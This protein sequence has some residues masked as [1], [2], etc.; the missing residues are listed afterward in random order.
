M[1][2]IGAA[3]VFAASTAIGFRIARDYRERPRQLRSLSQGIRLLQAEVEY[4][5]T[6][7]PIALERVA[8]RVAPPVSAGFHRAAALLQEGDIPVAEA[9]AAGM[10]ELRSGSALH[11]VDLD[12]MREL[13]QTLGTSDRAHQR[14]QFEVAIRRLSG[15]EEDALELQRTH[16]RLW[17]YVGALIGLTIV[18]LLY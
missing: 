17:R 18:I 14:Q 2:A 4:G 12:V 15:L 6:P 5:L 13:G 9:V 16:E 8:Q 11:G 1:K 10:D 3:L 7:L